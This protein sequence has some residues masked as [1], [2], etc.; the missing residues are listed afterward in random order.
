M[1]TRP[2]TTPMP[3]PMPPPMPPPPT[4]TTAAPQPT[5]PPPPVKPP[6]TGGGGSGGMLGGEQL[7]F[8][9][10]MCLDVTIAMSRK[11]TSV[12]CGAR[13][14]VKSERDPSCAT[15]QSLSI[16]AAL[17][18]NSSV[19]FDGAQFAPCAQLNSLEFENVD[20]VDPNVRLKT[21][22]ILTKLALINTN[23]KDLSLVPTDKSP[24][25][26][27]L[28]LRE[29]VFPV[30]PAVLYERPY[31][32]VTLKSINLASKL[33]V[34]KLQPDQFETLKKNLVFLD[35]SIQSVV[36]LSDTCPKDMSSATTTVTAGAAGTSQGKIVVCAQEPDTNTQSDTNTQADINTQP[37]VPQAPRGSSSNASSAAKSSSGLSAGA[38]AGIVIAVLVAAVVALVFVRGRRRQDS[39]IA[40]LSR[41]D[42]GMAKSTDVSMSQFELPVGAVSATKAV[43]R[44]RLWLGEMDGAKVMLQRVE[45]EKHSSAITRN[46]RHDAQR[47]STLS[48]ANVVRFLGVTW[49]DGTDSAV[50][51]E[52]MER[53]TLSAVLRDAEHEITRSRQLQMCMDVTQALVYLH[54]NGQYVKRLT[55]R[56]VLVAG[57]G[58]CK[59]NLLETARLV[60]RDAAGPQDV[61]ASNVFALGVLLC[62][63]LTREAPY[64]GAVARHG[65]TLADLELF[66][67]MAARKTPL[68]PHEESP[69]FHALPGD[70][71]DVICRC[72]SLDPRQRPTAE[73]VL[74]VLRSSVAIP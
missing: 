11:S 16:K 35:P 34:Q 56:E 1:T 73:H 24:S 57:D 74:H 48:H 39:S 15:L 12:V 6:T 30:L 71:R 9:E 5:P 66:A 19:A 14:T 38:I 2:P 17:P 33:P 31:P 22:K 36:T 55:S 53:G 29:T 28:D 60:L 41:G 4:A 44:G 50:V 42:V 25:P 51:V 18:R 70:V 58:V 45:A 37:L 20:F 46:L 64:A 54:A 27:Q 67:R 63:I 3:L 32:N 21:R 40:L 23:A 10:P 65:C 72:L 8:N 49:V 26:L 68:A 43:G 47:F 7:E 62:E 13:V 59:I 52:H 61:R 69:Q